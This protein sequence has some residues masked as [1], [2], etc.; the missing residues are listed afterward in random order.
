MV[1]SVPHDNEL[2]LIDVRAKSVAGRIAMK[3]PWGVLFD[4]KGQLLVAT[5]NEVQRFTLDTKA[6]KLSG[7]ATVVKSLV[8]GRSGGSHECLRS[9][10]QKTPVV[11]RYPAGDNHSAYASNGRRSFGYHDDSFAWATLE[12]GRKNEDWF[13]LAALRKAGP[14]R[15][16][17]SL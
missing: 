4:D 9:G 6:A 7:G 14:P 17:R 2:L 5:A 10:V 8:R 11:L 12:T 16:V 13:Y 1:T 15:R 3:D